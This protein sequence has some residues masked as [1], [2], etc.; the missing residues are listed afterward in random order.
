MFTE[1]QNWSTSKNSQLAPEKLDSWP[2]STPFGKSKKKFQAS[3]PKIKVSDFIFHREFGT[4]RSLSNHEGIRN[5]YMFTC[6]LLDSDWWKSQHFWPWKVPAASQRLRAYFCGCRH[7]HHFPLLSGPFGNTN[8]QQQQQHQWNDFK[9]DDN[10]A[11]VCLC[12]RIFCH[13]E[14][15]QYSHGMCFEAIHMT[16]TYKWIKFQIPDAFSVVHSRW[17][18]VFA[19]SERARKHSIKYMHT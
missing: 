4:I 3:F 11:H 12:F 8:Q 13:T 9:K 18:G 10:T 5:G 6:F 17:S 16:L 2:L 19:S 1:I 7:R 15:S 14:T